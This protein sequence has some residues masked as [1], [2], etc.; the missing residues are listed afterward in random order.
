MKVV[1]F[2]RGM[3]ESA[4]RGTINELKVLSRLA[5][6]SSPH[7]FL[8]QPYVGDEMWAWRSSEGYLHVLTEYCPGGDLSYYKRQLPERTLALICAE[9]ILGLNHLHQLGIVHHDLKPQN[10]LVNV[11][12]H[13][14]VSDYGGAQFLDSSKQIR[15]KERA[16]GNAVLTIPFAA[17]ELL[18]EDNTFRTYNQAVDYWSLGATLVSLIMDDDMLPGALDTSFLTFRV[19]RIENKM[20]QLGKS[21]DFT[22]FVLA[23]LEQSPMR[24]LGYPEVADHGFLHGIDWQAVMELRCPR[25]PSIASPFPSYILTPSPFPTQRFHSSRRSVALAH[26]FSVE[27]ARVHDTRSPVDFLVQLR[28]EQLSL[29]LDD[30]FDVKAHQTAITS[31][32]RT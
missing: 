23:L 32:I 11:D 19:R 28:R 4:C 14:V 24:R 29:V 25:K 13:C 12:G 31:P 17:P 22:D 10:I 26:G 9:V 15:R 16:A 18:Y 1:H 7:P 5:D 2:A 8:L 6:D 20:H 21:Q 30:S 27:D 3:S